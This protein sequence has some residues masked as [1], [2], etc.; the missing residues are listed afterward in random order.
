MLRH[1]KLLKP[2][3]SL[4]LP[5]LSRLCLA[6]RRRSEWGGATGAC[7]SRGD[8]ARQLS[9]GRGNDTAKDA[10]ST[11]FRTSFS[12]D[13]L[14]DLNSE[15][16]F[17]DGSLSEGIPAVGQDGG[18]MQHQSHRDGRPTPTTSKHQQHAIAPPFSRDELRDFNDE[19]GAFV[20]PLGDPDFDLED[21]PGGSPATDGCQYP[22]D[23]A[24]TGHPQ[25]GVGGRGAVAS[26]NVSRS[27]SEI[28][29]QPQQQWGCGEDTN[30]VDGENEPD[31]TRQ[32]RRLTLADHPYT[33]AANPTSLVPWA[34]QLLSTADDDL[35][36]SFI[37]V[38]SDR[39]QTGSGG[40]ESLPSRGQAEP[41]V[42]RAAVGHSGMMQHR[43]SGG[44]VLHSRPAEQHGRTGG[45]FG[46]RVLCPA[47]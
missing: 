35:G 25:L 1:E 27:S 19:I 13:D 6:P 8:S 5:N 2:G 36:S 17:V 30:D 21:S 22:S 29:R 26:V 10:S 24:D 9:V 14:W 20:G 43:S 7:Y 23:T 47:A 3:S 44:G 41:P 39:S 18:L 4:L 32:R 34:A 37:R 40:V 16:G 46:S 15:I 42:G 11:H 12:A 33:A 45:E 38:S 28:G 31:A